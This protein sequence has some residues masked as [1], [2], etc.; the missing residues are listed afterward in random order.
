MQVY[1]VDFF[2]GREFVVEPDLC[3]VLM[4]FTA[5][6]SRRT[7]DVI[8]DTIE[9]LNLRCVRADDFYGKVVLS[10]IWELI[11]RAAFVIADL[12]DANPNVYYELGIAH[13]I[14]K[15]IIP[16]L[17]TGGHV[18]FDQQ[19]FR[20]LFYEDNRDGEAVLR[21]RLPQWIRSLDYSSSPQMLLRRNK[22]S[23]FNTWRLS[24]EAPNL[25]RCDLS[26][27]A[28]HGV[29]FDLAFL[30]ESNFSG[31]DLSGASLVDAILIRCILRNVNFRGADLLRT[32]LS[33]AK[34][35]GAD[36]RET[37][38]RE[39][40]LIRARLDGA[41]MGDAEVDGATI[42]FFTLRRYRSLFDTVR[43]FDAMIIE[44][45]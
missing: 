18:P 45:G 7:Y 22:V 19:P 25:T 9:G 17:Q 30:T 8:K 3:F 37:N 35:E 29:D 34:L 40:I 1:P 16:L 33:E 12:T 41:Q 13:T 4:P 39:S 23:Q 15:D 11:N 27:L 31:S 26:S 14:G 42:D 5:P 24:N 28:L 21:E 36:L 32:N 44:S 20:I 10:D 38:L 2:T 43:G 6:W